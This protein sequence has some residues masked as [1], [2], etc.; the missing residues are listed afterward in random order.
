MKRISELNLKGSFRKSVS[1]IS[2]VRNGKRHYFPLTAKRQTLHYCLSNLSYFS[3]I[4]LME[5]HI[6]LTVTDF[7]LKLF[8]Y[9]SSFIIVYLM[10]YSNLDREVSYI[11]KDSNFWENRLGITRKILHF[12][13]KINF[14]SLAIHTCICMSMHVCIGRGEKN[15]LYNLAQICIH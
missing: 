13:Q 15:N 6:Q 7:S 4:S 5:N 10:N 14:F 8:C 11:A 12:V 1:S 2:F 3:N 9:F